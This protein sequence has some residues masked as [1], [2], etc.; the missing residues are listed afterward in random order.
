MSRPAQ[1]FPSRSRPR[2]RPDREV[3]PIR[4]RLIA[5]LV[6]ACVAFALAFVPATPA[7]AQT[8]VEYGLVLAHA[9]RTGE[10]VNIEAT[11]HV[12]ATSRGGETLF[13]ASVGQST[14]TGAT[15]GARYSFT[16]G[17]RTVIP[18]SRQPDPVIF[19]FHLKRAGSRQ[20][21]DF[22]LTF[23]FTLNADGHIELLSCQ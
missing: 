21:V 8:A 13:R 1:P 12:V 3:S 5:P 7:R 14:A 2:H 17:G 15:T 23:T 4:G 20:R 10:T 6:A 22:P 9:P 11:L 16:G 19:T 18:T